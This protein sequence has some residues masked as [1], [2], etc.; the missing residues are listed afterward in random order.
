MP[1]LHV[2]VI[3]TGVMGERHC[4][5]YA[6]LPEIALVGVHDL[7]RDR[8][9][10]VARRYDTH[11]FSQLDDLLAQVD[12]ISIVTPTPS[13]ADLACMAL[14]RGVH[15]LIEKP[16]AHTL[17]AAERIVAAAARSGC[18]VQV[19]HIERFNP[20]FTELCNVLAD[21][22]P[23]AVTM[24]RL[25]PFMTSAKDVDVVSDLM[26]HDLD[27]MLQLGGGW[28]DEIHA[29]GRRLHDCGTDHVVATLSF[30]DGPMA[31]LLASRITE[32]KVRDIAVVASNAY[33]EADLLAKRIAIHH[34]TIP[35]YLQGPS[36][37]KY[38]QESLIEQIVVPAQEPLLLELR[39]FVECIGKERAPLVGVEAGRE[40]LRLAL[41]IKRLIAPATIEPL[42]AHTLTLDHQR[43]RVMEAA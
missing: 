17:D 13:H 40:A 6:S 28:P 41:E 8:A 5:V 22:R 37:V 21:M 38:R 29:V 16:L 18:L 27:L 43:A 23:L 25:S 34:R 15:V 14:E 42:E 20:T 11:F 3:G 32:Q 4:R 19:G 30:R 7:S 31:T 39:H 9:L 12:A 35:E 36:S 24:R 1:K 33:V 2:G 10:A 26:I